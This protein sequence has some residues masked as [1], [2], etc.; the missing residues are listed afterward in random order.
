VIRVRLHKSFRQLLDDLQNLVKRL[1]VQIAKVRH[2]I[3]FVLSTH[4]EN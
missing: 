1:G 3:I 2:E 4:L